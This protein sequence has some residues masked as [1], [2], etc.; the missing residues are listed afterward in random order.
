M[1]T[2]SF[3]CS[4][5]AISYPYLWWSRADLGLRETLNGCAPPAEREETLLNL[6][7]VKL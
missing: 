5:N 7:A 3:D 6:V 4:A 1:T 2:D